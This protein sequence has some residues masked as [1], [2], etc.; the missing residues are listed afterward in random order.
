MDEMPSLGWYIVVPLFVATLLVLWPWRGS[1]GERQLLFVVGVHI[2][3]ILAT[4]R[5]IGR[6]IFTPRYLV[7]LLPLCTVPPVYWL[8]RIRDALVRRAAIAWALFLAVFALGCVVREYEPTFDERT[9]LRRVVSDLLLEARPDEPIIVTTRG[10]YVVLDYYLDRLR[11]GQVRLLHD[12]EADVYSAGEKH[13][14][15]SS[16]IR[17][18]DHLAPNDVRVFGSQRC[19]VM[20]EGSRSWTPPGFEPVG[21]K[22]YITFFPFLSNTPVRLSVH[23]RS[24]GG[25]GAGGTTLSE[26]LPV[27]AFLGRGDVE[28]PLR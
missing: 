6:S 28:E 13:L 8:T 11:P 20:A 18:S 14:V 22:N 16:A 25:G 5:I 27:P 21:E 3:A 19:W 26:S 4:A 12:V 15:F 10:L 23:R 9:D 24:A 2:V 17:P 7:Y 1:P